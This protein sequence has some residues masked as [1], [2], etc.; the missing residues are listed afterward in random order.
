VRYKRTEEERMEERSRR[1][2][3]TSKWIRAD[4][5]LA[6]Y[7]R[8]DFRCLYC[9]ADLRDAD[10]RDVTLDHVKAHIDGGTNK[11]SNL[12]TACLS[13]NCSKKDTPVALFTGP[14]RLAM[15]RRNVRRSIPK[16]RRMARAL[17]NPATVWSD[18]AGQL[19]ADV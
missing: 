14:E 8:D 4:L 3:R 17:M 6:I 11:P 15:I 12:V 16:F 9:G 19:A 1:G 7:L 2:N 5:R 18:E 10:P 13:C